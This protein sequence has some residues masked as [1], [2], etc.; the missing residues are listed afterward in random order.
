[1]RFKDSEGNTVHLNENE[2][3]VIWYVI[4][5]MTSSRISDW[6]NLNENKI[7]YYKLRAK[8]KLKVKD[9]AE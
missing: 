7:S 1:M 3:T 5:G 8:K 9:Y 6:M 2:A 4:T